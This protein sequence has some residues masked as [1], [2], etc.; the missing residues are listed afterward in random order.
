[1]PN[2]KKQKYEVELI[3]TGKYE[4]LKKG[5][6]RDFERPILPL[7]KVETI[8]QPRTGE[9]EKITLWGESA[10]SP[11]Y[12][13]NYPKDWKNI[14]IWGDNKLAMLSLLKGDPENGIPPMGGKINLIYIDPP[15]FTGADFSFKVKVGDEQITKEPSILEEKAYR[16]LW[17]GGIATYLAYMYERLILMRELLAENGSIYVH[18]DWHV[19]NDFRITKRFYLLD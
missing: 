17:K 12:P 13:E 5:K 8:N 9:V 19:G 7:Q 4:E 3:W 18:L 11:E 14:L 2:N 6:R 1:M 10:Q 15:F 16:D